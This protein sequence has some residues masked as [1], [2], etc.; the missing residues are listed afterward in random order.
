M[1]TGENG[2][3]V[4][5]FKTNA[6]N[7]VKTVNNNSAVSAF[8][9]NRTV[10]LSKEVASVAVDSAAGQLVAKANNVASINLKSNGVYLVKATTLEGETAIHKVIVK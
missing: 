2:Y 6:P 9:N 8:V 5:E 3:G 7:S 1:Y 10:K 4:Y